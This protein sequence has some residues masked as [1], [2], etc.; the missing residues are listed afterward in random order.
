MNIFAI[1]KRELKAYFYSPIA[2]VVFA[3]FLL[4]AGY[5]FSMILLLSKEASMRAAMYNF[6]ITLLFF[7]PLI[8]MRLFAEERK[9]GTL[10]VLMT[11]PV[12]DIEVVLGKFF[13]AL[14]L[15]AL[16]LASTLVYVGVLVKYGNPDMGPIWSGYL[17]L[18]LLGACFIALGIFAS[19]LT[20]SQII[21]AVVGFAFMLLFWVIGWLS[22]TLGFS[23][24][25][26]FTYI[27]LSSHFDDF[28]R[29]IIDF[30]A[31]IYYLSFVVFF[32]FVTVKSIE[33]R[34]WK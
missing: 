27:S 5:F 21:A 19:T 20:E 18:F 29:G 23:T 1:M 32:L 17:G 7:A 26:I 14:S 3:L 30:R 6:V 9:T 33:V 34:K 13:A 28:V 11:R 24:E 15:Y 31:V 2:Y 10:E 16:M 25:S 8:T 22:G 4:L 12:R